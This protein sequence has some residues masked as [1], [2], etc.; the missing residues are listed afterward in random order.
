MSTWIQIVALYFDCL[1]YIVP[2]LHHFY[3]N[4]SSYI[5]DSA[6]LANALKK[7]VYIFSPMLN[8]LKNVKLFYDFQL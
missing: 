7:V 5:F 6:D 2:D 8:S 3:A 1:I 4:V